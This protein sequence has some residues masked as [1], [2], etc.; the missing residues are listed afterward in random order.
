MKTK[1]KRKSLCEPKIVSWINLINEH[2]SYLLQYWISYYSQINLNSYFQNINNLTLWT[3]NENRHNYEQT[4]A[5]AVHGCSK[6]FRK[7]CSKHLRQFIISEKMQATSLL[8]S[9][10]GIDY[11]YF[12]MNFTKLL[13][14]ALL[15][16][17]CGQMVLKIMRSICENALQIK[18]C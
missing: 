8:P 1:H 13:R 15:Q 9:E 11:Q 7:I 4:S 18:T 3:T 12:S 14:A 16:N 10:H 2:K 5:I 17:T 6:K